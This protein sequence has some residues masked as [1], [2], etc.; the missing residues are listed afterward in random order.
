MKHLLYPFSINGTLHNEPLI[1]SGDFNC[2]FA[3]PNSKLIAEYLKTNFNL[4]INNNV[5][6]STT[7]YNTT[8]D[9]VFGRFLKNLKSKIYLSYFSDHEPIVK[10]FD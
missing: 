5:S 10:Y 2:N 6:K 8:I 7:K 4:E 3:K 9:A 1:I